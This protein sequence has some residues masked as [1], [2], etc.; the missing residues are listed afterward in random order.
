MPVDYQ[1]GK[2]YK[3]ECMKTNRVYIGSTCQPT[4]AHRLKSLVKSYKDYKKGNHN[5][6][7][8]FDIFDTCNYQCLLICNFSCNGK[9]ELTAHKG[10]WIQKY[11]DNETCVCVN[12]CI[13]GRTLN[14]WRNAN[15][16]TIKQINY[17]TIS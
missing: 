4:V 16:K 11:K 13:P 8:A 2:I 17:E 7:T 14:Q 12:T 1:K 10:E 15:K 9:D 6:V 5:H 3:I